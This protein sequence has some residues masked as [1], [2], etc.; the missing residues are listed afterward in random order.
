MSHFEEKVYNMCLTI[1]HYIATIILTFRDTESYSTDHFSWTTFTLAPTSVKR[2][3]LAVPLVLVHRPGLR[4]HQILTIC[5][6]GAWRT[7]SILKC[8]RQEK[9]SCA[10][11]G[12]P[13]PNKGQW[14]NYRKGDKFQLRCAELCIQNGVCVLISFR[15]RRSDN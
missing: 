8:R 11:R 9:I 12:A 4:G 10:N 13:W 2:I 5:H 14:W 1:S 7:W 3:S 15:R 6:R